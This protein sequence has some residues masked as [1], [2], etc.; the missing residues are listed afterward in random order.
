VFEQKLNEAGR[1]AEVVGV[2]APLVSLGVAIRPTCVAE[3]K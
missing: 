3:L 2:G 1:I